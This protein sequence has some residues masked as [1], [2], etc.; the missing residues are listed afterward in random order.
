MNIPQINYLKLVTIFIFCNITYSSN[1]FLLS[2]RIHDQQVFVD[3]ALVYAI[4][5]SLYT[6]LGGSIRLIDKKHISEKIIYFSS[7]LRLVIGSLVICIL[8][9]YQD[10]LVLILVLRKTCEWIIDPLISF[11]KERVVNFFLIIAVIDFILLFF[12]VLNIFD[13]VHLYFFWSI[14]PLL[15]SLYLILLGDF[16]KHN[17]LKIFTNLKLKNVNSLIG[18]DGPSAILAI[19]FRYLVKLKMSLFLIDALFITMIFSSITTFMVKIILPV[20]KSL[21]IPKILT[22]RSNNYFLIYNTLILLLLIPFSDT[23]P[24]KGSLFVFFFFWIIQIISI[25]Y[26]QVLIN[27]NLIN[28][29]F[30][31]ELISSFFSASV[32]IIFFYL[33]LYSWIG[34]FYVFNAFNNWILYGFYTRKNFLK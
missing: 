25:L 5:Y 1:V 19:I 15:G 17:I 34:W 9:F 32:L 28:S 11:L 22:K 14:I 31:I 13:D 12:L 3:A 7:I 20:Y 2:L 18:F 26:R 27:N 29:V 10:F 23:L 24:L 30:K 4:F 8:F 33:E 21:E 6:I 16:Y